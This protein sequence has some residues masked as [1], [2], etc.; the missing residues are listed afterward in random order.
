MTLTEELVG[1]ILRVQ[2]LKARIE[3]SQDKSITWLEELELTDLR[4]RLDRMRNALDNK[5]RR[6]R[7]V[8]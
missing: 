4:G 6:R 7:C 2:E 3:S 1:V 5:K 8:F